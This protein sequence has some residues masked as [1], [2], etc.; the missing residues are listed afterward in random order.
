MI[1]IKPKEKIMIDMDK[2]K[3]LDSHWNEVMDLAGKY[4]FFLFSVPNRG[5][6]LST[7]QNFL[8]I[9]GADEYVH[10]CEERGF[11]ITINKGGENADN[12]LRNTISSK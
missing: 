7:H 2:I 11:Y 1:A 10:S 8:E 12:E 4:G 6:E 9:V 3:E 5:A